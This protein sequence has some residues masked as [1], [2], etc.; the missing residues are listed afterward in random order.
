M[1]KVTNMAGNS[2]KITK[3]PKNINNLNI[4][5]VFF[6]A[7][8]IYIIISVAIYLGKDR[9]IPY[10]VL[11]GSLSTNNTYEAIALRSE[12]VIPADH[13]GYVY[14]FAAEDT[15]AAVGDLV[16][17]VDESGQFIEYLKSQG[18]EEVALNDE[19]MMEL[20]SQ[21]V[22]FTSSFDETNFHTVYDFKN[23]IDGT[24]QKLSNISL[25][26][27]MQSINLNNSIAKVTSPV[28]GIVI[29]STDGYENLTTDTITLDK[30]DKS[31]YEKHQL[32]N[33]SL[34][35]KGDPV[36]KICDSE[37]WSIVIHVDDEKQ[38]KELESHQY[39]DVKFI[40]NQDVS[41]A[42][43][44]S[45]TNGE[46]EKF[47]VLSF[48]NS[49]ITFCR[50]RF[51]QVEILT[52]SNTGLKIPNSAI[53]E[54]T[55]YTIPQDFVSRNN[56]KTTSV[57]RDKYD[58]QGNK[59]VER[60]DLSIYNENESDFI[61]GRTHY[62]KEYDLEIA[63]VTMQ[64][65]HNY[66]Y[67]DFVE[68]PVVGNTYTMEVTGSPEGQYDTTEEI[69]ATQDGQ[70]ILLL[71]SNG[72][73]LTRWGDSRPSAMGDHRGELNGPT[74][75]TVKLIDHKYELHQ[76]NPKFISDTVAD[77]NQNDETEGNYIKNRICYEGESTT[78]HYDIFEIPIV[79]GSTQ[80][81][82]SSFSS[83]YFFNFPEGFEPKEG[84]TYTMHVKDKEAHVTW[85]WSSSSPSVIW[86]YNGGGTICINTYPPA[87][88]EG[89]DHDYSDCK[90]YITCGCDGTYYTEGTTL[91]WSVD[92]VDV[93]KKTIDHKWFDDGV[94]GWKEENDMVGHNM[95][96]DSNGT[97]E[98][99]Y[100][101]YYW[102]NPTQKF[103]ANDTY[104][105]VLP[106]MGASF[107]LG[108][109]ATSSTAGGGG[110]GF[111]QGSCSFSWDENGLSGAP[112]GETAKIWISGNQYFFKNI[113]AKLICLK[114]HTIDP[115]YSG[116]IGWKGTGSNSAIFNYINNVASGSYS[117]AEGYQTL[118]NGDYSHAEG[119][120]TI[121]GGQYAHVEGFGSSST[122]LG[123]LTY[124]SSNQF[125]KSGNY[126][127]YLGYVFQFGSGTTSNP[128]KYS[129]VS[130]TLY[131]SS[132]GITTF[133]LV[134]SILSSD[135]W[136]GYGYYYN[137][138]VA[139]GYASHV[140]GYRCFA[141]GSYSHAEG[142]S[143][144]AN[145]QSSHA[146]GRNTYAS[147][148][149]T[150]AEGCGTQAGGYASHS[151]GYY[152]K[153][154]GQYSH[155]EGYFTQANED[156][157]HA[158][159]SYTEASNNYA[160]AEG[161]YTYAQGNSS[162]A[163]GQNTYANGT[164]SHAEGVGI[165]ATHASQHAFGKFNALDPSTASSSSRGTYIEIVGNGTNE[166]TRSNA[167]TLD[168]DGNEWVAGTIT[169]QGKRVA[170]M[171]S[172]EDSSQ[173]TILPNVFNNCGVSAISTITLDPTNEVAD[174]INDYQGVLV[175]NGSLTIDT[176]NV[177]LKSNVDLTSLDANE[178]YLFSIIGNSV[179]GYFCAINKFA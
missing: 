13:A 138:G 39:V 141:S 140:E 57:L 107:T 167:R 128:Y 54:K 62:E 97:M 40:K 137:K 67:F 12:K 5:V 91:N 104:I 147:D 157:S 19:S 7:V 49:M 21:I 172:V 75:V 149:C 64:A 29:Y 8:A 120:G 123:G 37:D 101:G 23:S 117:F 35:K 27:D 143:T 175:S 136:L 14:Y 145:G 166:Q 96:F 41:S 144:T 53:V 163:E 160:H 103:D 95:Y 98:D 114:Y 4:G 60:V 134:N 65:G 132:T 6:V 30:F 152:T 165:K 142:Y 25:L 78:T 148:A 135:T 89:H 1:K 87:A 115:N 3:Y 130:S 34:V 33:N 159:G 44:S 48:T 131:N 112:N 93:D 92:V 125:S 88:F 106:E 81:Q 118:A 156:Y 15:R 177:S 58:E 155:S 168:W 31:K 76:L 16:Y 83:Y 20:R 102:F 17:F 161:Y 85:S 43:V 79:N 71:N 150:H 121:A 70:N 11:E 119:N 173:G 109:G 116:V 18:S 146:E 61:V 100:N 126:N 154:F 72:I 178:T 51:L 82:D 42:K 38:A 113:Y 9:I 47:F 164:A 55:F 28:S 80:G 90:Y 179:L 122:Y 162:H 77:W 169:S 59:I 105:V 108:Q 127:S 171:Y 176:N 46:G 174:V 26:N 22:N 170:L 24:V 74:G 151:E 153:A 158:E 139:S 94:I 63:D 86:D 69:T 52:E 99:A 73:R 10:Q 110:G 84:E 2:R 129:T 133:T 68:D 50:D 111:Y 124:I 66:E 36:Y 32:V 45:F 56:D